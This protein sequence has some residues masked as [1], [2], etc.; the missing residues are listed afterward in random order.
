MARRKDGLFKRGRIYWTWV[1][2]ERVSCRTSD[3]EAAVL[4]KAKLERAAADPSYLAA[5]ETTFGGAL[6]SF[7]EHFKTRKRSTHTFTRYE[8]MSAHLAR[9]VDSATKLADVQAPIVDSY[10][11]TRLDEGCSRVTLGKE[12]TVL[13]QTLKLAKRHGAYPFD[14][15]AVMPLEFETGAKARER[16][17]TLDELVALIV[18]LE[19]YSPEHAR[20][21]AFI[22]ATGARKREAERARPRD[23]DWGSRIVRIHGTKTGLSLDDVPILPVFEGLLHWAQPVRFSTWT[24]MTRDLAAACVRA[25]IERVTANDLRRTT[26]T[27]LR[28]AGASADMIARMLRHVDSRMVERVYGRVRAEDA[29]RVIT[30][31]IQHSGA[32]F[33]QDSWCRGPE[34]NWRHADFQADITGGEAADRAENEAVRASHGSPDSVELAAAAYRN[35]TGARIFRSLAGEWFRRAAA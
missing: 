34:L 17:L 12:L 7:L 29:G 27:L 13:R 5:N 32:L 25:G 15:G 35:S 22:V 1:R 4:Y 31:Q 3:R 30:V 24:N 10:I 8:Q 2:G 18:A 33:A 20:M 23:V 6:T 19:Q 16:A 9:V 21:T 28:R 26:A 11:K 14:L